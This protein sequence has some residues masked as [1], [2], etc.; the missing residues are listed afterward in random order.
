MGGQAAGEIAS[1]LA[2]DSLVNYFREVPQNK[3][4]THANIALENTSERAMLLAEAIQIAN[5]AIREAVCRNEENAGMGSTVVCVLVD[6]NFF[7]VG[8]W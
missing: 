2:V 4:S 8:R 6:Q 1:K 7:S 5:T 3:A